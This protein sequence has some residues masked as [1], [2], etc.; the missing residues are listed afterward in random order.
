MPLTNNN[1]GLM[2]GDEQFE[3]LADYYS[4]IIMAAESIHFDKLKLLG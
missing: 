1:I 3:I 2:M 4:P